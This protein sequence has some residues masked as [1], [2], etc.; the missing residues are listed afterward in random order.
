MYGLT[1]YQAAAVV[2]YAIV[3]AT[4]GGFVVGTFARVLSSFLRR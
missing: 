3:G 2:L 1:E 4:L